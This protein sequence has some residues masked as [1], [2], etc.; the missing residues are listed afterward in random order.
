MRIETLPQQPTG[1]RLRNYDSD[2]V[3]IA[4]NKQDDAQGFLVNVK[5]GKDSNSASRLFMLFKPLRFCTNTN[6]GFRI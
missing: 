6:D 1:L 5:P 4:W 3:H 2:S